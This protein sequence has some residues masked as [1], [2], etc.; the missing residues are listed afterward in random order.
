MNKIH[1]E[2]FDLKMSAEAQP[3][4]EAVKRHI[5][6]NVEPITE[7]YFAENEKKEDRWTH[8]PRQRE[9]M[10]GAKQKAREAGLWNFF[11]PD[12]ESGEGLK[13]L[14]FAYLAAELGKAIQVDLL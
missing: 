14:D 1:P 8:T 6:E 11:L 9:L 10:E 3:L 2:L 13:N 4:L 12:A 5:A 7:E